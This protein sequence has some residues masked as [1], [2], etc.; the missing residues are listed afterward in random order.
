MIIDIETWRRFV[1]SAEGVS[2]KDDYLAWHV[3]AA[4]EIAVGMN[5]PLLS[6]VYKR[7]MDFKKNYFDF[8]PLSGYF[9][10][11]EISFEEF[12]NLQQAAELF[13]DVV[14]FNQLTK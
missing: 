5:R 11:W 12:S 6:R 13:P 7:K 1:V 8:S 14:K 4:S 3:A 9:Y 2:K 10:G